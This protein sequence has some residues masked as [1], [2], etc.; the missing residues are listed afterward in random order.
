M[1]IYDKVVVF[2]CYICYKLFKRKDN[3]KW[4]FKFYLMKIM[5]M[6]K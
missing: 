2:N 4:Y 3:L 5:E 1:D 6:N